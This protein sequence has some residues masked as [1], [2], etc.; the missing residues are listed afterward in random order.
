MDLTMMVVLGG[1]ERSPEEFQTLFNAAGFRFTAV[2]PTST[3]FVLVE[4]MA[5]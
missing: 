5:E 1:K 2:K 4:A 3:P